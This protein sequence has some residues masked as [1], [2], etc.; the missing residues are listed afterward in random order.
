MLCIGPNHFVSAD[1]LQN[2]F[3][4]EPNQNNFTDS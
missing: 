2:H 3:L 1:Q 4:L